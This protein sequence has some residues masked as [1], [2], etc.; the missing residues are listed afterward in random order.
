MMQVNKTQN[1]ALETNFN[2]Y[3]N[4]KKIGIED[5]VAS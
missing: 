2:V 1:N 4:E 3:P 5:N